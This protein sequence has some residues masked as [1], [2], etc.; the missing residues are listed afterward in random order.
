MVEA[1]EQLTDWYAVQGLRAHIERYSVDGDLI[2]RWDAGGDQRPVWFEVHRPDG[3]VRELDRWHDEG[4]CELRD[5]IIGAL[6]L[7]GVSHGHY[8]YGEAHLFVDR[9]LRPVMRVTSRDVEL[10]QLVYDWHAGRRPGWDQPTG[11]VGR[12]VKYDAFPRGRLV[13]R[14]DGHHQIVV[15]VDGQHAAEAVLHRAELTLI[16][17]IDRDLSVRT[18]VTVEVIDGDAVVLD[19]ETTG[20]YRDRITDVLIE[21]SDLFAD[22]PVLM[23]VYVEA[24]LR[25]GSDICFEVITDAYQWLRI[26]DD[27]NVELGP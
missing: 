4:V 11:S 21:V 17:E 12:L 24:R 1:N 7:P 20:Y 14:G 23:G 5:A 13:R 16:G 2:A 25:S 8:H 15:A 6:R 27:Q 10:T 19:D 3:T 18:E 26:F 22:D 9:T